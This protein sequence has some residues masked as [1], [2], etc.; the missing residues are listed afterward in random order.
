MT[1]TTSVRFSWKGLNEAEKALT[2]MGDAGAAAL[3]EIHAATKGPSAGL[4]AL[5]TAAGQVNSTFDGLA[6]RAGAAGNVL[7]TMGPLGSAAAVGLGAAAAAAGSLWVAFEAAATSADNLSDAAARLNISPEALQSYRFALE[8]V[9]GSAQDA[10]AGL[11]SLN[12]RIG[13]VQ[14]GLRGSKQALAV[15]ATMG[16]PEDVVKSWK[17][18][19]DGLA[20]I[21][22]GVKNLKS[23]AERAKVLEALGMSAWAPAFRD[24]AAG[25]N[26]VA[27]AGARMG[28]I[29]SNDVVEGLA[30]SK[31]Q[32][33]VTSQALGASLSNALAALAP[34]FNWV[35]QQ[36]AGVAQ[37]TADVANYVS[38]TIAQAGLGNSRLAART[39]LAGEATR[40][41]RELE[42]AQRRRATYAS[43]R[44]DM[45][46]NNFGGRD[47]A[48]LVAQMDRQIAENEAR[49][50]DIEARLLAHD[51]A[52]ARLNAPAVAPPPAGRVDTAPRGGGGGGGTRKGK[53][54]SRKPPKDEALEDATRLLDS[55]ERQV[56]KATAP[57]DQLAAALNGLAVAA[58]K[59]PSR[60]DDAKAAANLLSK[61][62]IATAIEAKNFDTATNAILA[63]PAFGVAMAAA[64]RSHAELSAQLRAGKI[65]QEEFGRIL[66]AETEELML[67]AQ[68]AD[69]A[70]QATA[71]LE[72]AKRSLPVVDYSADLERMDD[73]VDRTLEAARRAGVRVTDTW[74]GTREELEQSNAA[75]DLM[76]ETSRQLPRTWED[77]GQIAL[78]V[79]TDIIAKAAEATWGKDGEGGGFGNFFIKILESFG[80]GKGGGGTSS[81]SSGSGNVVSTV[82]S[83]IAS[84]F[85]GA[86]P[87]AGQC[88][89]ARC[90]G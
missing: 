41:N 9:G 48:R 51:R 45:S 78:R 12:Q 55:Y 87:A 21:A 76:L 18:G 15:F 25:F 36:L 61:E 67:Q 59:I 53:A 7:S 22:E 84:F 89:K 23:E 40:L 35:L 33:E 65:T 16:I 86:A 88:R 28:A 3:R 74:R 34:M 81:T 46:A 68:A 13:A 5:D 83:A 42:T 56:E 75:L 14:L 49:R 58:A 85:G 79:L 82:V 70:A 69:R 71:A 52:T 8:E 62:F 37:K 66:A 64:T 31:R 29:M 10:D 38:R 72:K 30:D 54:S 19:E 43:G 47:T 44:G 1:R 39:N 57:T 4:K 26:D 2:A 90:I 60:A 80:G 32:M 50:R 73:Q 11:E 77:F 24:G 6:G 17:S 20:A 63:D 27:G